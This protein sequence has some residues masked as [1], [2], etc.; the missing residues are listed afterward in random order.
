MRIACERPQEVVKEAFWL[1]WQACGGPLGM[2]WLQNKSD[3]TKYQVWSNVRTA[4]DYGK[5]GSVMK[6]DKPGEAYGDY[7]FGRMMKLRIKWGLDYVEVGDGEPRIDY[8]AWCGK[9]PTY[10]ALVEAAIASLNKTTP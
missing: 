1:A 5:G 7:V 6:P 4:G 8:Q 10:Q 9:Y 3:V 2:G